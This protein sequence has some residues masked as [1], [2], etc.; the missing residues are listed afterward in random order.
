ME[1]PA[2][3]QR[4]VLF[5]DILGFKELIQA[6]READV[7]RALQATKQAGER[8]FH[9]ATH[10]RLTAFSDSVVVSDLVADGFGFIRVTQ[11]ASYL[12][13]QLLSL[14]ILTRGA[15]AHGNLHHD[16]GI[17]FG[18]ALVKAY[19]MESKQAI[20]PRILVT[21][22]VKSGYLEH[23]FA[24]RPPALHDYARH[25]FRTDFDGGEHLHL[26]GSSAGFPGIDILEF[27]R[28]LE[29]GQ[30][31]SYT[32]SEEITAKARCLRKA[33]DGNQ[34]PP[35]QLSAVAKHHWFRNYLAE[36]LQAYQLPF[37]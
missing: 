20:Y 25:F 5:L 32:V 8:R 19:A 17:V 22:E 26:M 21:T 13:W 29:P 30:S 35:N 9:G 16:D 15:V 4:V 18:P 31:R 37:D 34:P 10:M 12:A 33:L 1:A 23:H 3:E 7:W 11:Y 2:Y 24:T 36:T 28:P 6:N 27:G 14:G